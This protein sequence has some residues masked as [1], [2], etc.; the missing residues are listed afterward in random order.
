MRVSSPVR[1]PFGRAVSRIVI[2]INFSRDA[3]IASPIARIAAARSLGVVVA[4][5]DLVAT[6]FEI[7]PDTSDADISEI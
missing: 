5:A 3:S 6:A 1:R 7:S 2:S 4:K